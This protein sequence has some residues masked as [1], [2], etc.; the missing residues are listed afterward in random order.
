MDVCEYV[1]VHTQAFVTV[2]G[3]VYSVFFVCLFFSEI[4]NLPQ[5][6]VGVLVKI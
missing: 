1:C 6:V 5:A 3:Q 4:A 2:A